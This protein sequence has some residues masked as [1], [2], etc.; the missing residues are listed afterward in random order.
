LD[1]IGEKYPK[2]QDDSTA[3]DKMIELPSPLWHRMTLR[4]EWLR[5][6]EEL[7]IVFSAIILFVFKDREGK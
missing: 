4:C 3:M 5:I 1:V 2:P 7:E 6:T